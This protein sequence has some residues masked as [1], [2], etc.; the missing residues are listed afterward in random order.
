MRKLRF[1]AQLSKHYVFEVTRRN[2][3]QIVHSVRYRSESRIHA[4]R[5]L[6][7]YSTRT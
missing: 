1:Y 2:L 6:S 7:T 3:V 5:A 4:Q